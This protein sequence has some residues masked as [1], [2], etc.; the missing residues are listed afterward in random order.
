Y[1][2]EH[3]PPGT[4]G[5]SPSPPWSPTVPRRPCPVRSIGRSRRNTRTPNHRGGRPR[6]RHDSSP[7]AGV[8][9]RCLLSSAVRWAHTTK[10]RTTP[11]CFLGQEPETAEPDRPPEGEPLRERPPL[12]LRA[13]F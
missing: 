13:D 3:I 4:G 9:G 8:G 12:P 10:D 5:R 6:P 11:T 2:P 7:R 1:A